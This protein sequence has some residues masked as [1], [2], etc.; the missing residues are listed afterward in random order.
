MKIISFLCGGNAG[1][2]PPLISHGFLFL[3]TV[4]RGFIRSLSDFFL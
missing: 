4:P 2:F 1:F 3:D